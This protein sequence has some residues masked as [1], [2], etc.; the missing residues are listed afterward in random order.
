M[1]FN[2]KSNITNRITLIDGVS[3]FFIVLYHELGGIANLSSQF[4]VQFLG[5]CGLLL[6]TFSSGLKM[7]F[8]HSDDINKKSFLSEYFIK[9]FIRL[10]K[11]YVGCTLLMFIPLYFISYQLTNFMHNLVITEYKWNNIRTYAVKLK[12]QLHKPIIV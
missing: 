11:A 2:Y 9:R 3:I 1:E 5:V 6:F 12:D 10:Y 4:L 8:N 7:G